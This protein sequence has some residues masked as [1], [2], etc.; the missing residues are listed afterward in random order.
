MPGQNQT[1]DFRNLLAAPLESRGLLQTL[2]FDLLESPAVFQYGLLSRVILKSLDDTIRVLRVDLHQPRLAVTPFARDQGGSGA[3][4]Q[5]CY[6]VPALAA[7]EQ[8]ALDQF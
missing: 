2:C 5:V 6:D 8:R 7:V 4:E 1:F 3:A